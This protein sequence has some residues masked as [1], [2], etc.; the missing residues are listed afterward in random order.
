MYIYIH[1]YIYIYTYSHGGAGA[2]AYAAAN[3]IRI[4]EETDQWNEYLKG[5]ATDICLLEKTLK[6]AFLN[7]DDAIKIQQNSNVSD[8]S[9]CTSVTAMITPKYIICANAG[10]S[11]CVMGTNKLTKAMSEDHKPN[12]DSERRRIELAGG[13]VQWKRV[14]GDLAVSRALGDFQ[15]KTRTDLGPTE[16]KV[17][18]IILR[19]FFF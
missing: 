14:D 4:I 8:S 5:G 10:D 9:G 7:I 12:N 3:M 17:R 19:Y 6:L 11:R 1:I 15:Y 13:R 2:A 18:K 16:Q